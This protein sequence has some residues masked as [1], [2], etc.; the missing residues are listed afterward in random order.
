M[1]VVVAGIILSKDRKRIL[2]TQREGPDYA[3]CWC[4]PGGKMELTDSDP[5]AALV[6]ELREEIG[7]WYQPPT[8]IFDVQLFGPPS[9]KEEV[10]LRTYIMS[11]EMQ[12]T[13][14]IL[15]LDGTLGLGWFTPAEI[16]GLTVT[17]GLSNLREK[18][19]HTFQRTDI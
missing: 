2:L 4:H 13:G 17:P 15:P 6:R 1:Q 10:E 19:R 7:V 5:A 14:P 16:Y 18:L 11:H 3:F 8:E 12:G 9:C